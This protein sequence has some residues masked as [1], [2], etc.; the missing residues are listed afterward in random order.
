LARLKKPLTLVLECDEIDRPLERLANES[1]VR[2]ALR[3]SK[4]F[5]DLMEEGDFTQR[6]KFAWSL[7][8]RD[9]GRAI[10]R[11]IRNYTE[12]F[13]PGSMLSSMEAGN[14]T[15]MQEFSPFQAMYNDYSG[16]GRY[17]VTNP[18][19]SEWSEF[20]RILE[21]TRGFRMP[22]FDT[23]AEYERDVRS[24]RNLNGYYNRNRDNTER[25]QLQQKWATLGGILVEIQNE[26][27]WVRLFPA[28]EV[29]A[30]FEITV[31]QAKNVRYAR[32]HSL[33]PRKIIKMVDE[34]E[35]LYGEDIFD[36]DSEAVFDMLESVEN[37]VTVGYLTNQPATVV[38]TRGKN[39][40]MARR[41]GLKRFNVN[42]ETPLA[43]ERVLELRDR[44]R[45]T[46]FLV[47]P[48]LTDIV[49]MTQAVP[50]E[51]N[52]KLLP[53]QKEAVGLHLSTSIGYLQTCSPGMGKTVMQLAAMQA[54]AAN[55]SNYR[56]IVVC[57]A[58]LRNQWLEETEKWFPEATVV[59][60]ETQ[61]DAEVLA[62]AL[63]EEKP[64]V[65]ILSYAHT[66]LGAKEQ[67]KREDEKARLAA[68][69]LRERMEYLQNAPI[70]DLTV[71]SILLDLRWHDIA[72]D[73]AVVIRNG[74]SKQAKFLWA[75][76]AKCDIAV[77]LTATPINKSPDDLARL[78]AWVRNDP[79]MFT[80]KPLS[81]QYDTT[82]VKGAKDLFKIFG[83]L[84]FRRDTSELKEHMPKAKQS[85]ILLEPNAAE[86][87]LASAAERE[88]KRCYMELVAAI[89]EVEKASEGDVDQEQLKVIRENL[90]AANG[91]WLG[92]TQLARMATSDPATLQ[93]SNSV[94]AALLAGQGLV[95]AAMAEEP[96][97]RKRFIADAQK[98]IAKGQQILVFTSFATVAELLAD[99]L[100]ENGIN[101]KAYTGKNGKT[102]DRARKEFQ[103]GALDVL[104]C[105]K[106]AER[107]LTL[108]KASAL[109]HYD[110]PWTLEA[111]IQ[112]TGRSIRY[113]S[114][115]PEVD[116]VF[117]IM[118]GTVEQ[119]VAEKLVKI[120]VSASLV[121]DYSRTKT[122]EGT[123]TANAMS[124]L[125]S[126]VA[127]NSDTS[128]M[129]EFG[130]I[131][132]LEGKP[133]VKKRKKKKNEEELV[134]A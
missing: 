125:M 1:S 75:L 51:G 133:K 58:A 47:H 15:Q 44:N 132:G 99:A 97:K 111:I 19:F 8:L 50:Y 123:E 21:A 112:R 80:G 117:M 40:F 103:D 131:L 70:P 57:D 23:D 134:A 107:G 89:D 49:N 39:A 5:L 46:Q 66:L 9:N 20:K 79:T 95:E 122:L 25:D 59:M 109:Y 86:K 41:S 130:K 85:V 121:M 88:L 113:G 30:K 45:D 52:E 126:A 124:G 115:N 26:Q 91:A 78:V 76:R 118:E 129:E 63:A 17:N 74:S 4:D 22:T 32:V 34:M 28:T 102:R 6:G 90:R 3:P 61:A 29:L 10:A 56:G 37:T 119:R 82:T 92:G 24:F 106:A 27:L 43:I 54:R 83:P 68:M 35:A 12:N 36:E 65:V 16:S 69:N 38:L 72:A 55:I 98:R 104:V 67:E 73:E 128:Q 87:A 42:E 101:A 7:S 100:Q 94:G 64:V 31:P 116:V 60:V 48:G 93:D 14:R 11:F 13:I 53:Y 84:V 81:E 18:A 110:L 77:A 71:G 114:E 108:H 105:T 33:A 62:D 96:T 120:G 127:K 2:A